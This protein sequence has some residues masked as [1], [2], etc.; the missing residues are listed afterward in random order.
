VG[1]D[2]ETARSD[3]GLVVSNWNDWGGLMAVAAATLPALGAITR[4]AWLMP[5][6]D[7]P[8]QAAFQVSIAEMTL[9]GLLPLLGPAALAT[10]VVAYRNRMTPLHRPDIL[11]RHRTGSRVVTLATSLAIWALASLGL[12]LG[13]FPGVPITFGA[14][15]VLLLWLSRR[16]RAGNRVPFLAAAPAVLLVGAISAVGVG[17]TPSPAQ[18]VWVTFN[19]SS[20]HSSG[21]YLSLSDTQQTAYLLPC[22]G[23]S[24]IEVPLATIVSLD[25]GPKPD[26]DSSLLHR[27]LTG[28]P[29]SFG[30]LGVCPST[31]QPP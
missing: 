15:A 13:P 1:E 28:M 5:H 4:Y 18:P 30:L 6:R 17:L 16:A 20:P 2:H 7:I 25:Y 11:R 12:L 8:P 26:V 29:P 24:T 27:I 19:A 22:N 31:G 3:A 9:M 23:D 21:W 14:Y 10:L